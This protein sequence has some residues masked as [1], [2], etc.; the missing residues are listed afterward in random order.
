MTPAGI[1]P[2]TL[3]FVAQHLNHCA[4]AV[5][6]EYMQMSS[7]ISVSV[8]VG[9]TLVTSRTSYPPDFLWCPPASDCFRKQ[10]QCSRLSVVLKKSKLSVNLRKFFTKTN[11]RTAVLCLCFYY[12]LTTD[13][14]STHTWQSSG[15]SEQEYKY[16]YNMSGYM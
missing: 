2:A 1:E 14:S 10:S 5:P 13:V 12:I 7:S 3:R 6:A 4:I 16:F 15:W 8:G 11:K 9:I